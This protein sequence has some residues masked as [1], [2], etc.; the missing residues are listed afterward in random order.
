MTI[1][2]IQVNPLIAMYI[3]IGDDDKAK[4]LIVVHICI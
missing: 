4:Q 2:V 1:Q 3:Y